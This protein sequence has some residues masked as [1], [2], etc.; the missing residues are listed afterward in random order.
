MCYARTD[1]KGDNEFFFGIRHSQ[2]TPFALLRQVPSS[3]LE[4][5]LLRFYMRIVLAATG[6]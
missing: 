1:G 3:G 5:L 4:P 2:L 6:E